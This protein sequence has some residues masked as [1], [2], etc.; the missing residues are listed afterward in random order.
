MVGDGVTLQIDL[1]YAIKIHS[2][3]PPKPMWLE[4]DEGIS[5]VLSACGTPCPARALLFQDR[6][7]CHLGKAGD[8]QILRFQRPS[9]DPPGCRN[10][11]SPSAC[12][13]ASQT[14]PQSRSWAF[15]TPPIAWPLQVADLPPGLGLGDTYFAL[16]YWSRW[17]FN[18]SMK[19][20]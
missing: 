7:L 8:T 16:V 14:G 5:Q 3:H 10:R 6:H 18:T 9:L 17:E 20:L 11:T 13:L 15:Q 19:Q 12:P 2:P 4:M 1:H